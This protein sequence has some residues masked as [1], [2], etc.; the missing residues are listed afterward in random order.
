ME[1][2]LL[3]AFEDTIIV[4]DQESIPQQAGIGLDQDG[5]CQI[6]MT[7][8]D[9][10]SIAVEDEHLIMVYPTIEEVNQSEKMQSEISAYTG[11]DEINQFDI[12]LK[13]GKLQYV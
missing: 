3:P 13:Y 2:V 11:R 6:T 5:E 4:Y 8:D 9:G 12:A 1:V 10:K 7:F